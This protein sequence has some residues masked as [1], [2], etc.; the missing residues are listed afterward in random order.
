MVLTQNN[1][2]KQ[3]ITT[4]TM[5]LGRLIFDDIQ[6]LVNAQIQLIVKCNPQVP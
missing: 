3:A 1:A 4:G 5:I 6:L 2:A